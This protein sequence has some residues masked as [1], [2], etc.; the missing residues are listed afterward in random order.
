MIG[1]VQR[2]KNMNPGDLYI[3]FGYEHI[4]KT[5]VLLRIADKYMIILIQLWGEPTHKVYIDNMVAPSPKHY[6]LINR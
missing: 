6:Q 4:I 2:D 3:G 1:N 5:E